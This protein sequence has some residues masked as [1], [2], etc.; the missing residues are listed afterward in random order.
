MAIEVKQNACHVSAKNA[1]KPIKKP[2]RASMLM[3]IALSAMLSL[4]Q[5]LLA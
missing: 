5:P 4:F 1:Q 3:N 2:S